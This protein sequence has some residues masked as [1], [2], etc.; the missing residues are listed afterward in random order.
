MNAN[1]ASDSTFE[2]GDCLNQP[3]SN[4]KFT[5]C[6]GYNDERNANDQLTQ[7]HTYEYSSAAQKQ[8]VVTVDTVDT[9]EDQTKLAEQYRD[10]LETT[11]SK[12]N[13]RKKRIQELKYENEDLRIQI[14]ALRLNLTECG[15]SNDDE[16]RRA[17]YENEEPI[18]LFDGEMQISMMLSKGHAEMIRDAPFT[19]CGGYNDE[20]NA[21]DQLTQ[22]HTYEYSSA[23]QKQKVVTVDTVDTCE[24]QTKLAE[25]YR[26][27]LETTKSKANRRKKRIQA[28]KD[29]NKDLRIEIAALK[30]NLTEKRIQALNDE[31]KDL[32]IQNVALKLNLTECGVKNTDEANRAEIED[33]LLV[34]KDDAETTKNAHSMNPESNWTARFSELVTYKREHG[35]CNVSQYDEANRS[36]G[37]WVNKQR[38]AF[39]NGNLSAER[40]GKLNELGFVWDLYHAA[41]MSSYNNLVAYKSE[42][43]DC[44]VPRNVETNKSL[45]NWVKKQRTAFNNGKLSV[46][47]VGK[48]NELGFVWDLY[49][50][51]WMSS[52]NNLV[53][54]KEQHGHCN[55]SHSDKA[56]KSLYIWVSTQRKVFKRGEL[57][58]ERIDQ[59]NEL[60]FVFE[61]R[62][63]GHKK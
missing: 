40:V 34:S 19:T 45:C 9:C 46:E 42:H 5:A 20:R 62:K 2:T 50:A 52:Y 29:K 53:A 35:H 32:R 21:N 43:G 22:G 56:N 55:V 6:R 58:E 25:Q 27:Q 26:D 17:G 10:Q 7:G 8:K 11:K 61:P 39:N 18:H 60:G 38:I 47:R 13:R 28:L 3:N 63:H 23:A 24:D 44:N 49:H 33:G 14:A 16:T 54:Y 57:S 59:L 51:A 1:Q 48:L 41:W 37:K 36:L 30:L 15:M 4:D 31:N 12:A